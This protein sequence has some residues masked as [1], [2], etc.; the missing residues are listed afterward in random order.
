VA[1]LAALNIADQLM[2]LETRY[3]ALTGS[4]SEAETS[5]RN[6]ASNLTGLLDSVLT[7]DRRAG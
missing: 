7:G 4:M 3:R 5:I 6:R 1:V 2:T